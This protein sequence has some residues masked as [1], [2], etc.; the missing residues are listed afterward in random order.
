MD[1]AIAID[2]VVEYIKKIDFVLCACKEEDDDS[3]SMEEYLNRMKT[4]KYQIKVKKL[5]LRDVKKD[6][7]Y[8]DAFGQ[9]DQQ[10]HIQKAKKLEEDIEKMISEKLEVLND[11]H[12]KIQSLDDELYIALLTDRYINNRTSFSISKDVNYSPAYTRK[13]TREALEALE[14]KLAIQ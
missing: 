3:L 14:K 2:Q 10:E 12:F 13:L 4:I 5:E 11:I 9:E 8:L 7:D 1:Y 6:I